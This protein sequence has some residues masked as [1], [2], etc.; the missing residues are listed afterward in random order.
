MDITTNINLLKYS[1]EYTPIESYAGGNL[2]HISNSIVYKIRK[3]LNIYKSHDL[4]S[5]FNE[6]INPKNQI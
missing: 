4:E 2:P 3:N 1:I 5:T 6:I